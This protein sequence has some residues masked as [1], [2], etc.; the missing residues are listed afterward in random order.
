MD[1][2]EIS[3]EIVKQVKVSVSNKYERLQQEIIAEF[4]KIL[5][6]ETKCFHFPKALNIK[7]NVCGEI[8]TVTF[9][10]IKQFQGDGRLYFENNKKKTLYDCNTVSVDN[11]M[12]VL[13]EVEKQ[14]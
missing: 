13:S 1:K 4:E 6:N 10:G 8:E 12:R 2:K 11:L 7:V 9:T 14:L 5:D 3:K